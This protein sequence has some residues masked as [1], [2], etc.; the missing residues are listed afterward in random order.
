MTVNEETQPLGRLW[1]PW[2][3]DGHSHSK[4]PSVFLHLPR[5]RLP[6]GCSH[7]FISSINIANQRNM[8]S[9]SVIPSNLITVDSVDD[10][11]MLLFLFKKNVV[12]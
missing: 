8:L 11:I 10:R 7:S 6:P 1:L 9:G 12:D 4:E 2:V 3:P 5:H